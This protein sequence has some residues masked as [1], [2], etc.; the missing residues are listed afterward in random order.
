MSANNQFDWVDY[1]KELSGKL[2]SYKSNRQELVEK[3]K[4]VFI[5]T[6][7]NMPTLEK[8]NQLVDIDPFTVFGLFNKSSMKEANRVKIITAVKDLFGVAA[9]IPTSFASIPVL[10]N[11]NA[12]FYYFVGGR[13]D[14]D[15]DDLWGLFE[16]ALAYA[17]SPTADKRDVLSK[18]F[19]LAINKKGNGNSKITMGLYWIAPN[20]FLNLDQRNTWYIYESGKVPTSLVETLPK[21]PSR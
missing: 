17:A 5:N 13:E 6:G 15:I 12:T 21:I 3:V 9:P 20:A 2:L 1:Y 8:D 4:L 11:Q 18:Y 7:I 19:D 14:G 10:N 16:S